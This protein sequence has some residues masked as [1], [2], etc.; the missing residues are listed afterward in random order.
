MKYED[1]SEQYI[2]LKADKSNKY[3]YQVKLANEIKVKL[4]D[5]NKTAGML[6]LPTGG[7]KTRVAVTTALDKAMKDGYKILWI[8]HRHMLI[9]QAEQTFYEFSKLSGKELSIKLISGKHGS[10][11]SLD[12]NDDVVIISNMSM[13]IHEKDEEGNDYDGL[14]RQTLKEVLFTKEQKW[15]IIVDEAHHSLAKSYKQWIGITTKN[16]NGWL[17]RYRKENIK[18]LGLTATPNFISQN[19]VTKYDE[20]RTKELSSIY[21]DNLIATIST[22]KLIEDGILSL[23]N[24][25]TIDTDVKLDADE[26]LGKVKNIKG[27]LTYKIL[28]NELNEE[29]AKHEG[30]NQ[31][32][33]NTYLNGTKNI[34]FTKNA[35]LIF[36]SNILNA[37]TLKEA[38]K[39]VGVTAD[40]IYSNKSNNDEVIEDF[41]NHK[42]KVLIN[43]E[44]LTEGSDIPEIQNVFISKITG[45]KILYR[46][47]VG[48]ALRGLDS[49]GTKTAN[50][51]TFRDNIIN[52]HK[53]FFNA[54]K[55]TQG[56]FTESKS[57]ASS[58]VATITTIGEDE[59]AKAYEKFIG[60]LD[61]NEKI[62]LTSAI[63]IG[64]YDLDEVDKKLNVYQH[65]LDSYKTFLI[66]YTNNNEI[67]ENK[68]IDIKEQYFKSEDM[69]FDVVLEDL[70]NLVNYIKELNMIPDFVEF[71]FKDNLEN[72]VR[73]I[74]LR[75]IDSI[76][77]KK[78]EED[79]YN[80]IYAVDFYTYVS[81][82]EE[83][84][85]IIKQFR[86]HTNK[87]LKTIEIKE[88]E[89]EDFTFD[90]KS[91]DK[92][93]IF[94]NAKKEILR[95]LN[96]QELEKSPSKFEW[97]SKAYR[98]YY[99][100]AYDSI[101][102][103]SESSD[104]TRIEINKILQLK[105]IPSK[106]IEFVVYHELL[107]T[108]LKNYTHDE[109][110]K[111][112]ETMYPDFVYCEQ[113][114]YKI[115]NA[116]FDNMMSVIYQ[117]NYK[118]FEKDTIANLKKLIKNEEL[119]LLTDEELQEIYQNKSFRD[120]L[121]ADGKYWLL[122][123]DLT[124][125]M[126]V[127]D[128]K[129]HKVQNAY[130]VTKINNIKEK[131]YV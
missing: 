12:K 49:G 88:D 118:V 1:K 73:K 76:D 89:Y 125:S 101:D 108:E 29:I 48:R 27:S 74:A 126:S 42:I 64:Y 61:G 13:G 111:K 115:A 120:S 98:S 80:S 39:R 99:G 44:I 52:Y 3:H 107:H 104:G 30:R 109:E 100:M 26:L 51:V 81:F 113:M 95:V 93:T 36:A 67:L 58:P 35:T 77:F 9:E 105:E 114:L 25:I 69:L 75:Y 71:E 91:H 90:E 17:R 4:L 62:E 57:K 7:G 78:L 92:E 124:K 123:D 96:K 60:L 8:A 34:D 86:H 20:N 127:S 16:K 110:F 129:F 5:S 103:Y 10:I 45:S 24:F 117:S 56:L 83:C 28:E 23:P 31:L 72:E 102:G 53:D 32:I 68:I 41:R 40:V 37:I 22:Q 11:K 112:Y 70:E 55:L 94:Q 65:Q 130:L 82:E 116:N 33:V 79:F 14:V 97:T 128:G 50:I 18:I 47:M 6:V 38:F 2:S 15:L 119:I 63:P 122:A 59:I 85:N 121:I 66:A 43:V 54:Q 19:D 84:L 87:P 106:V 46:Q 131:K 21:D